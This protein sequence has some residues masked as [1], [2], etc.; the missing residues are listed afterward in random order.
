ML[1]VPYI[2]SDGALSSMSEEEWLAISRYRC[3]ECGKL[4]PTTTDRR[5]CDKCMAKKV[6][7]EV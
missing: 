2:H 3:N 7:E 5:I 6:N 4:F 1:K